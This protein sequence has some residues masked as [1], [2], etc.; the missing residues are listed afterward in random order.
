VKVANKKTQKVIL[1]I[2]QHLL[3]H[4]FICTQTTMLLFQSE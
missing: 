3:T 4:I 2:V 1:F